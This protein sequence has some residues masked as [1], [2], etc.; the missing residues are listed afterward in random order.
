MVTGFDEMLFSLLVDASKKTH[1]A[2]EHKY[3]AIDPSLL[4]FSCKE[5]E[6]MLKQTVEEHIA[7]FAAS[8]ASACKNLLL[9]KISCPGSKKKMLPNNHSAMITDEEIVKI[10]SRTFEYIVALM[11]FILKVIKF[12]VNH[13]LVVQFKKELE[14]SFTTK[15]FVRTDWETLVENDPSLKDRLAELEGQ[16]IG[17]ND[18]LQ[19][20]KV[21]L[22]LIPGFM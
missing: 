15:L 16:I 10:L 11:D 18:S 21:V 7:D 3:L 9:K 1:C 12:Q 14:S 20:A 17:L 13:Y 2:L 5:N 4:P 19:I 22:A 6:E 8:T